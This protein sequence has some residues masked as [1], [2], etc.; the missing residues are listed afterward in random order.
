MPQMSPLNWISLF[1]SFSIIFIMMNSINYFF[2][3]Y[4]SN[5]NLKPFKFSKMNW[6]W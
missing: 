4:N 5:L 3:K 1:I 2:L 6:K